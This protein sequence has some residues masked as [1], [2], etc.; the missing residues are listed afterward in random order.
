MRGKPE[1][2]NKTGESRFM[3]WVMASSLVAFA[4]VVPVLS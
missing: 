1:V 3:R 2:Q 4:R